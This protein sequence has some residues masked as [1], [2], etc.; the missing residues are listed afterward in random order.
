MDLGHAGRAIDAHDDVLATSREPDAGRGDPD[1]DP[2][3][4]EDLAYCG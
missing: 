4:L 1:I 3:V 2:F